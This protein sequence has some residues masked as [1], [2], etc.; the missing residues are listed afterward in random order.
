MKHLE[1]KIKFCSQ[2]VTTTTWSSGSESKASAL[3]T[4]WHLLCRRHPGWIPLDAPITGLY[5]RWAAWSQI[6]HV[7]KAFSCNEAS[8][9]ECYIF[10]LKSVSPL[11]EIWKKIQVMTVGANFGSR[12]FILVAPLIYGCFKI[13]YKKGNT[14]LQKQ[15]LGKHYP[16]SCPLPILASNFS[17]FVT[18]ILRE[19]VLIQ[20]SFLPG[21]YTPWNLRTSSCLWVIAQ[22]YTL[23]KT[24]FC[25]TGV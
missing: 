9:K 11:V 12:S 20:K 8:L 21:V 16:W 10:I 24:Q 15:W 25:F 2:A 18:Q 3:S 22:Y 5:T 1:R 6:Y 19:Q 13:I 14:D 23:H 4:R 17:Q 7:K